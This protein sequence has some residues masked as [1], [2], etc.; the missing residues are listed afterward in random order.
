MVSHPNFLKKGGCRHFFFFFFSFLIAESRWRM[1]FFVIFFIK[2]DDVFKTSRLNP[3]IL[4]FERLQKRMLHVREKIV[5]CEE[6]KVGLDENND[7]FL[8]FLSKSNN[9][10]KLAWTSL[11]IDRPTYHIT[12]TDRSDHHIPNVSTASEV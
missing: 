11:Y 9:R 7:A 4:H 6:K 12:A 1:A 5:D 2:E 10:Q 3:C 8:S